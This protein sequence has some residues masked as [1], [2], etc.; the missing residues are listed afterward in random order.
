MN[1]P[2]PAQVVIDAPAS[3]TAL[4]A[5]PGYHVQLVV[6]RTGVVHLKNDPGANAMPIDTPIAGQELRNLAGI[7]AAHEAGR[8]K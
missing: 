5:P 2:R 8:A 4:F 6:T 1:Q 3:L 7:V